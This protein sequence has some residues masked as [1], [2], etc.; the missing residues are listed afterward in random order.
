MIS[1]TN[2]L[3]WMGQCIETGSKHMHLSQYLVEGPPDKYVLVD[4]GAEFR[5]GDAVSMIRKCIGD[6][7]LVAVLLTHSTLPHTEDLKRIYSEWP[8]VD[9]IGSTTNP[10]VTGLSNYAE[11]AEPKLQ[12]ETRSFGGQEFSFVDPLL[13]DVVASNWIYSHKTRTLFTAEGLG[14]YH[15]PSACSV[16]SNNIDGGI[17]FEMIHEFNQD[18][19]PFL[20]YVDVGKLRSG[21][22]TLFSRLDVRYIAPIHGNVVDPESIEEHLEQNLQ[23]VEKI[24]AEWTGPSLR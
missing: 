4:A 3:T 17:P 23:S 5:R 2:S 19:L 24:A 7:D 6:G 22:D 8:D 21:F 11:D 20:E 13:T 16:T 12:N 10:A 18:K 15:H 1:I 14:H 9:V